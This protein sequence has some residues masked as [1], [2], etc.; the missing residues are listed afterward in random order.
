MKYG[1]SFIIRRSNTNLKINV[2]YIRYENIGMRRETS[3]GTT[4]KESRYVE[5]SG[6]CI[7]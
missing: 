6:S 7:I 3:D 1:D 5:E 4:H 2:E